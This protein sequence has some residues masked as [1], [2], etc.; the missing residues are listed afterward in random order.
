MLDYAQA[1][2]TMVD[3]QLRT[4]DI[5]DRAVLA[6]FGDVPRERFVPDD[7]QSLAYMDQNVI[8]A[9]RGDISGRIMLAPMVFAR[10]VQ[11]LEIESGSRVLDVG[12]GR[13][14]GSAILAELGAQVVALES[15]QD[16]SRSSGE[17]LASLGLVGIT[18]VHG[19]LAAGSRDHGPY[20]A[21]VVNGAV[22][23]RPDILLDQLA[24]NGRLACL[25]RDG[26]A[27]RAVL[28]VRSANAVGFRILFDATA[29]VLDEFKPAPE[30]VF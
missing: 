30:F 7:R 14:Y 18:A 17:T 21:I 19:P 26:R 22:E 16:L 9:D 1:R 20:D 25:Q 23:S 15:S 11:S 28:Y 27:C 4:F 5:T 13:G 10:L 3:C 24:S 2:R 12:S 6:V 8:V 29:P